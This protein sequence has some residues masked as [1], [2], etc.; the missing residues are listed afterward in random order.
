MH[1]KRKVESAYNTGKPGA[2]CLFA[3]SLNWALHLKSEIIPAFR[4]TFN[5]AYSNVCSV[6]SQTKLIRSVFRNCPFLCYFGWTILSKI[7]FSYFGR[8]SRCNKSKL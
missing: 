4:L 3:V 8:L 6:V 2:S 1:L 7:L 5:F